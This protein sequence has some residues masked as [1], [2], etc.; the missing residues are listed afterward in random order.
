MLLRSRGSVT[1]GD[2]FQLMGGSVAM[3]IFAD[4]VARYGDREVWLGF[5]QEV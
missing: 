4:R 1:H 5:L 3:S 2:I